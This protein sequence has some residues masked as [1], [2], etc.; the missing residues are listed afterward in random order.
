M[1]DDDEISCQVPVS[2]CSGSTI[3]IDG[4]TA[5]IRHAQISSRI[6]KQLLSIK[7]FQQSPEA[8]LDAMKGL[9]SQLRVWKASL[10]ERL[11]PEEIVTSLNQS[12]RKIPLSSLLISYAYWGTLIKIHTVIAYPWIRTVLFRDLESETLQKQEHSSS[13]VIHQAA[14][15]ILILARTFEIRADSSQW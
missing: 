1:I 11:K 4:V 7:A 14:R 9:D 8:L 3:D 2:I 15:N 10:P 12:N 13:E 5:A 6:S